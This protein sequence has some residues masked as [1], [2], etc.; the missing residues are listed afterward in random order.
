MIQTFS[1]RYL[2]KAALA[3]ASLT[4]TSLLSAN[5]LGRQTQS[6]AADKPIDQAILAA[7]KFLISRQAEDGAWHSQHYGTMKQGAANTALV[8][9]ALSK[10]P[11]DELNRHADSIDLARKFLLPGIDKQGCVA[12]PDGSLDYPIY[13]TAMIL[14][15]HKRIDLKLTPTQIRT[16]VKYLL[17]SQCM[18]QRGFTEKNPN[19]GGW[20][21]LGPGSTKGKTAGA[22]VSVTF[23]VVEALSHYAS[24]QKRTTSQQGEGKRTLTPQLEKE[25]DAALAAAKQW[26]HRILASSSDGGFYFTSKVKSTLN[27]AGW[28]DQEMNAPSSYGSATCDGLGLLVNLG[29]SGSSDLVRASIDWFAD[30]PGVDMAPGFKAEV[31]AIGWHS[32]LKFYY[33]AALS[34]T[35]KFFDEDQ[36]ITTGSAISK[37]LVENQL[38][39]GAWRNPSSQMREN[40]ELI[41]TPLGLIALLNCKSL[42]DAK[43]QK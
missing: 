18:K 14:T 11:L 15:V 4:L 30:H 43:K 34:R 6:V 10:L 9:Y 42:D 40:D 2:F 1:R 38:G 8:L 13:T 32:G 5:A 24:D 27:K 26:C 21:I 25:V 20:D 41:A 35:M 29:E 28:K 23:Y 33:N 19:H 17:D 12:N 37:L 36:A 16:M 3:L 22:N 31:G 39:S 7:T